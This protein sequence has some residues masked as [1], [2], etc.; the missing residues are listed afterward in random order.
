MAT[1]S[2]YITT[3]A[4]ALLALKLSIKFAPGVGGLNVSDSR[5]HVLGVLESALKGA[6]M[7]IERPGNVAR[8]WVV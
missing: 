2:K 4:A 1:S 5:Y 7:K 6:W 3:S 8:S